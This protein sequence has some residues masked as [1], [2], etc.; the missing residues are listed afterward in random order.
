MFHINSLY[1]CMQQE[2][3]GQGLHQVLWLYGQD[4]LITEVGTMNIFMFCIND[5]GGKFLLYKAVFCRTS[6]FCGH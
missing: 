1:F 4:H 2:A 6:N 3:L 5:D